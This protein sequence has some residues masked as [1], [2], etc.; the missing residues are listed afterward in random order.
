MK[1]ILSLI[2]KIHEKGNKFILQEL[3]SSGITDLAPSH[4][5]ILAM[6]YQHDKLTMKE[7]ADKIHR[8][9]PTVTILVAKLE[10]LGF[11]TREKSTEDSRITYIML[12]SKSEDFKPIFEKI[13]KD[14]NKML[15]KNLTNKE[16]QLLDIIL[17]LRSKAI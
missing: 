11:V 6:L 2:S 10:R 16:V 9:K 3:N 13:S 5:D 15:F 1:Q 12:T 17:L 7:I 14:L 4:G 8:S